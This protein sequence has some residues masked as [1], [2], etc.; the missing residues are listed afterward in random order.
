MTKDQLFSLLDIA[1]YAFHIL[2]DSD[3][4]INES[5]DGKALGN[6]L[7]RFCGDTFDPHETIRELKAAI[8]NGCEASDDGMH[9][10]K[11]CD[12]KWAIT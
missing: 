5:P 7:N 11:E 1:H 4:E 9:E 3:E 6:A 2:D 8:K 12:Q 10:C